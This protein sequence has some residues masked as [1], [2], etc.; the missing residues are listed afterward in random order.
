MGMIR[1]R[2]NFLKQPIKCHLNK[3]FVEDFIHFMMN[4]TFG[5]LKN[6]SYKPHTYLP[7]WELEKDTPSFHTM[8]MD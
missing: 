7:I 4:M 2:H 5:Y 1:M 3:W 8:S 6:T